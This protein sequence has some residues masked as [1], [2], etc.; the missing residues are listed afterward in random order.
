MYVNQEKWDKALEQ[1]QMALELDA[2]RAELHLELGRVYLEKNDIEKA[3]KHFEKYLYLGGEKDKD[4][5][6]LLEKIKE[7]KDINRKS[8]SPSYGM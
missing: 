5:Q 1:F 6:Q 8:S 3:K 4:V 7:N 2:D